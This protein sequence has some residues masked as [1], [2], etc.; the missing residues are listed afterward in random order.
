MG[1]SP[2][3]GICSPAPVCWAL[4]F[5]VGTEATDFVEAGRT[6]CLEI[7]FQVQNSA[8]GRISSVQLMGSQFVHKIKMTLKCM[9]VL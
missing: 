5:G 8:C 4:Q 2:L 9:L 1:S 3:S 7:Q 6:I